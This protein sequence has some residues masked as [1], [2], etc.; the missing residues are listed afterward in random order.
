MRMFRVYMFRVC[1]TS[2]DTH[3]S[4]PIPFSDVVSGGAS[5]EFVFPRLRFPAE[6]VLPHELCFPGLDWLC[7]LESIFGQYWFRLDSKW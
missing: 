4:D 1:T 2:P 7:F 6:I 3:L 5:S